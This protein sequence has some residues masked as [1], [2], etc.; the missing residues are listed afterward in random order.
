MNN[1]LLTKSEFLIYRTDDGEVKLDVRLE[2]ETIWLTQQMMADLF[3]TTQQN[4]SQHI[5]NIIDEGEL[6]L[7]AT[8][9]KF[10][11][12]QQE[13]SRQVNR[14]RDFYNLDM[15]ISIGYRVKSILA[16]RFRIWATEHLKEYIVKGYTMDDERLKNPPVAGSLAPDYFDEMLAR[17]RDIR[18]SERRM[19]LR[20]REI[21]AMAT[22]YE[23]SLPET[24]KFFSIIQN[25][26]HFAA[27]GMT[28]GEIVQSRAN[29][30]PGQCSPTQ[31]G[32]DQLAKGRGSQDGCYDRQELPAGRR[33]RRTQPDRHHVAGFR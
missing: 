31:H 3:R 15:I 7:E 5:R 10:L 23:P 11:S 13:G 1:N 9:K 29:A 20:V 4:I 24:S 27:T 26:I 32:L 17:I 33:D 22:D 30:V 2:D 28:A 21:F 14:E 18:S 16:T 19:Y 6:Q 8:H 25:K 12:V